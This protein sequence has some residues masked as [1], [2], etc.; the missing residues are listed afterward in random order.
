MRLCQEK[1]D[2]EVVRA[3]VAALSV[4][5]YHEANADRMGLAAPNIIPVVVSLLS[6]A[7]AEI[8]AHAATTLANL[9]HG[10]PNYQGD[11]GETG[12]IEALLNVCRGRAGC[13]FDSAGIAA[14]G[15]EE[16]GSKGDSKSMTNLGCCDDNKGVGVESRDTSAGRR[17]EKNVAAEEKDEIS[18]RGSKCISAFLPTAESDGGTRQGN[19]GEMKGEEEGGPDTMDVDAI[20]AATSALANLLCYS[21][22]N[23][24]R[25]V[26]AG[27]IGVLVGLVSSNRPHNLLDFDQ[28]TILFQC[29]LRKNGGRRRSCIVTRSTTLAIVCRAC[30]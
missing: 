17:N 29:K 16:G 8:Q 14:I 27:G 22:A 30:N 11:A 6:H 4:A 3:A 28:V 9:A 19:G 1:D 25:L 12:A 7:D 2:W 21:D 10:S 24:V 23:S 15:G 5:A 20:L 26:N 18:P 13:N